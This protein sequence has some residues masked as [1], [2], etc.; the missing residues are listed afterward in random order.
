MD[1][2]SQDSSSEAEPGFAPPQSSEQAARPPGIVARAFGLLRRAA[3][4]SNSDS[5]SRSSAAEVFGQ[6]PAAGRV[7]RGR[8][9]GPSQGGRRARAGRP[10][11]N[12]VQ[13]QAGTAPIISRAPN[14]GPQR[15]AVHNSLAEPE[16][17]P[18][19]AALPHRSAEAAAHAW[20]ATM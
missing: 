17:Q 4:A 7:G 16:Q 15:Q 11:G 19:Q 18:R 14:W 1:A 5:S 9:R 20:L 6:L 3:V 13:R 2:S 10:R 8:G 12:V